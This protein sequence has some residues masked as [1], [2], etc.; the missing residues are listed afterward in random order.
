MV[1][2][3]VRCGANDCEKERK[4]IQNKGLKT[5]EN[6]I[7]HELCENKFKRKKK[8][9]GLKEVCKCL[10]FKGLL[11]VVSYIVVIVICNL[12]HLVFPFFFS[13]YCNKK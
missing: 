13:F 6:W 8:K 5:N 12:S 1:V 2:K 4:I 9:R 10:R 7:T 3:T 11:F